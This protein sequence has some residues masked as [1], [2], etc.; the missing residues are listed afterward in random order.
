VTASTTTDH[1]AQAVP[2]PSHLPRF[3]AIP[4][5]TSVTTCTRSPH[6]HRSAVARRQTGIHKIALQ[7]IRSRSWCHRRTGRRTTGQRLPALAE[8]FREF[9]AKHAIY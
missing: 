9:A 5:W 1:G 4:Q 7:P 6:G 8:M 3:S 2:L